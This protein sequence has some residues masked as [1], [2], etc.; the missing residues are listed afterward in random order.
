MEEEI[1][2]ASRLDFWCYAASYEEFWGAILLQNI[3]LGCTNKI[4]FMKQ[5]NGAALV[6]CGNIKVKQKKEVGKNI[7]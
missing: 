4:S 2:L 1:V 7:K 5:G 6:N 3:G